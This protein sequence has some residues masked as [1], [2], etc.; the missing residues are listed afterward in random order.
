MK[1]IICKGMQM[2]CKFCGVSEEKYFYKGVCRNCL[3]LSQD[4]AKIE[5][6]RRQIKLNLPFELTIFQANLIKE[7]G[8]AVKQDVF[9]E[10]VCGAGKTEMVLPLLV[11]ML[12]QGKR[13]AWAIPRRE[14]V[15]ELSDRLKAY[16]PELQVVKVCQGF[17]Q[18]VTGDLVVCT[19]HQL[20]RYRH[21]FDLLILDEPDAF[22]YRDNKMLE[23]FVLKSLS[24][25]GHIVYL[26]AT[27]DEAMKKK[28]KNKEVKHLTLPIRPSLKLL[29]VPVWR[30]SLIDNLLFCIDLY[31][32]R[33]TKA[34][35]YVPTK[36]QA[37]LLARC[38]MCPFITSQSEDKEAILDSFRNKLKGFLISTTLLERGVTFEGINCYVL[39]ADQRVFT[40]AT[41]VQIA[42][43]V[44]RGTQNT[45]G[46]CYF[47]SKEKN[48]EIVRCIENINAHNQCACSVL[49]V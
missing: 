20:Y 44:G 31:R 14:I 25:T 15:I 42:G 26:S 29:P 39:Q 4:V 17:T 19:C 12:N 48:L 10:A 7:L 45:K 41:L 30:L 3:T 23:H 9:I 8:T 37:R 28:I 46:S 36:R 40:H 47:Y 24:E 6:K 49:E 32:N 1:N 5:G 18:C 13:C 38:L 27:V 35:I 2:K 33:H 34:I 16:F 22:P 21:Q 43:R 11:A